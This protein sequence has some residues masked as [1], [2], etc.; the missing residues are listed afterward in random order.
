MQVLFLALADCW[1]QSLSEGK[2]GAV[3]NKTLKTEDRWQ[4][5]LLWGRALEARQQDEDRID[6]QS[7]GSFGIHREHAVP[8]TR[9]LLLMRSSQAGPTSIRA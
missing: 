4:H 1:Q 2:R 5:S 3:Q 9:C 8:R 6:L 7:E